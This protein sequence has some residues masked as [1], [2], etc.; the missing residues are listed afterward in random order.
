M[1]PV[2]LASRGKK[3]LAMTD[4]VMQWEY[5]IV[6]QRQDN[7]QSGGVRCSVAFGAPDGPILLDKGA[8]GILVMAILGQAGWEMVGGSLTSPSGSM[9]Y[10]KRPMIPDHRIDDAS[11]QIRS[12][13]G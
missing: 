5:C 7:T 9:F 12:L 4:S 6:E 13:N 2:K 8:S 1:R 10:F 3:G 11:Q